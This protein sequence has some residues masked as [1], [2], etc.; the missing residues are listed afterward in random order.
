MDIR[1]LKRFLDLCE[2]GSF[3]RTAENLF[4]SQQVL[5]TSMNILEELGKALYKRTSKG[6]ILTREG[7][8]LKELCMPLVQSY[9]DMAL[10]LN[11]RFN[12]EKGHLVIG[13]A[14]IS[15]LPKVFINKNAFRR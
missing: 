8:I 13:L 4:L 15:G 14:L 12:N 9:D 11:R 1:Q 7:Q 5:S 6:V 2:T 10:E 3:T